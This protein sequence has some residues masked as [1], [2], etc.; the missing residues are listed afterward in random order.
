MVLFYWKRHV[1]NET[2]NGGQHSLMKDLEEVCFSP[3]DHEAA[4]NLYF[5]IL[6]SVYT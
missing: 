1:N 4:I 2:A 5:S 6:Y 3:S